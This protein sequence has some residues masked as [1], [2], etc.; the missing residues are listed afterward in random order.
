MRVISLIPSCACARCGTGHGDHHAEAIRWARCPHI[1]FRDGSAGQGYRVSITGRSL[2]GHL[3]PHLPPPPPPAPPP[4]PPYVRSFL[5]LFRYQEELAFDRPLSK[6]SINS[7]SSAIIP[8]AASWSVVFT[9]MLSC[10]GSP[11]NPASRQR[12][13]TLTMRLESIF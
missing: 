13:N 2:P 6:R 8:S 12:N 7:S 1:V 3:R 5:I 4:P 9:M 11:M 10:T